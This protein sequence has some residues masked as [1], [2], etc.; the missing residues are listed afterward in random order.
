M[1]AEEKRELTY[2]EKAV[3]LNF[4]PGVNPAV[5]T[6]KAAYA[7]IIDRLNDAR[8]AAGPGEAG[9]LFSCAITE[10]QS[11]Q[12]LAEKAITWVN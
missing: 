3:G 10:T 11:A 2:G 12:I 4:N 6:V 7:A 8:T 5:N 1:P 9:R